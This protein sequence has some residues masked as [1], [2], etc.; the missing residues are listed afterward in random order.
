MLRA[1][2]SNVSSSVQRSRPAR[3]A[4]SQCDTVKL[5]DTS[6]TATLR[7]ASLSSGYRSKSASVSYTSLAVLHGT[8]SRRRTVR[9]SN[10]LRKTANKKSG[11]GHDAGDMPGRRRQ[12]AAEPVEVGRVEDG[13]R[14][15]AQYVA[16]IE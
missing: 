12:G 6:V 7:T 15:Q 1:P 5:S 14:R 13:R 16:G 3:K 2:G 10:L 11:E 9:I 4:T 8:C